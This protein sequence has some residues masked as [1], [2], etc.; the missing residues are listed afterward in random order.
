MPPIPADRH[1]AVLLRQGLIFK[2]KGSE[3]FESD[4]YHHFVVLNANPDSGEVIVLTHGTHQ[5]ISAV[6]GANNQSESSETVHIIPPGK[7]AFFPEQTA[8]DCNSPNPVSFSKLVELMQRGDLI[9]PPDAALDQEDVDA[10]IRG[11]LA[12]KQVMEVIKALVRSA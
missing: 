12:S 10:L 6:I 11:V 8:F 7:Y 5:V 4:H 2:I 9:I 3:P 1:I